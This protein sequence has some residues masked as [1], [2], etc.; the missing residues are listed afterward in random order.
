M[1]TSSI[2][3]LTTGSRIYG[4]TKHAVVALSETLYTSLRAENAKIGVSVLCPNSVRTNM[5]YAYR[6]RPPEL[7][8]ET[9]APPPAA[10]R[11]ASDRIYQRAMDTGIDTLDAADLVLDAIR[12][13]QFW[14]LTSDEAHNAVLA[15]AGQIITRKNPPARPSP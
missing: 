9:N 3:G 5:P 2:A 7:M 12:A 4:V 10:E 6:N 11:A 14:V 1:N 8:D 13:D 15:R